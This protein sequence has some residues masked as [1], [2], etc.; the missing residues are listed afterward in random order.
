MAEQEDKRKIKRIPSLKNYGGVRTIQRSILSIERRTVKG[1][2]KLS[3]PITHHIR[4]PS[5]GDAAGIDCEVI[6]LA[7]GG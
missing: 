6:F 5:R 4:L 1:G 3:P 2:D 7:L